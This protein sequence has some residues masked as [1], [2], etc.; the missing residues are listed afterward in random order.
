V[1][2]A[3]EPCRV[4]LATPPPGSRFCP[5]CG[6]GL[7][8]AEADPL[9][10]V[11][12]T[13]TVLFCDLADSTA[14]GERLDPEALRTVMVRYYQRSREC[15]ERYGGT[16]EKFIGDAVVAVF[17]VPVLREDDAPRAVRAAADLLAAV[18]AL[19]DELMATVGVR[20]AVRIGLNTGEVVTHGEPGSAS[21]LASGGP[22]N[23]AARLQQHAGPGQVLLGEKTWQLAAATVRAEPVAP[24]TVK[25]RDQPVPAYRLVAVDTD[26]A[27]SDL[28]LVGREPEL[29]QWEL[30]LDRLDRDRSCQ[31]VTLL[32]DA[33][34]GKS[35]L[36]R[37][38]AAVAAGRGAAVGVGR[39]APHGDGPSLRALAQAL[40]AVLPAPGP[41][42]PVGEV[43]EALAG[44]RA[45]LL[46]DEAPGVPS[47]QLGWALHA[48][49]GW[50]S[51]DRPLVLVLDDL[52][53]ARQPLLDVLDLLA[54]WAEDCAVALV[55]VARPDL[56]EA[57]PGWG[58]GRLNG[59]TM[60][61]PPLAD[62]AARLLAGCFAETV[63]HAGP[64]LDALL[65]RAAGNPFHLE[66]LVAMGAADGPAAL[67]PTVAALIAARLE[68]LDPAERTVL[69]HAAVIGREFSRHSLAALADTDREPAAALRALCR[70]RLVERTRR[71][72]GDTGYRFVNT[73]IQ[74]VTYAGM[75]K[76]LRARLHL[77]LADHLDTAAGLAP[78]VGGHRE[79]AVLLLAELG[80]LDPDTAELRDR[81]AAHLGAEGV[82][83][84]RRSD[85]QH[86]ADLLE[87]SLRLAGAD[88]PGQL[89]YAEQLAEARLLLGDAG[90]AVGMLRA[91]VDAAAAAGDARVGG[92]GRLL[93]A[94]LEP[95]G[96][97]APGGLGEGLAEQVLPVFEAAGDDLG[98]ARA[99]LRLGQARQRR[100]RYGAADD[101]LDRALGHAV[102]AG[103]ELERATALGAMAFS[104]WHGPEP[105]ETA[106]ARCEG[107]LDRYVSGRRAAWA[108]V[109]CPLAVLRA[110]GGD[111]DAADVLLAGAEQVI[112]ELGHAYAAA[113]VPVFAAHVAGLAGRWDRAERLLTGSRA[114][115]ARL[116]DHASHAA[117]GLDLARAL[118][119]LGRPADAA[120]CLPEQPDGPLSVAT[121]AGIRARLLAAAGE[122]AAAA[123]W[124]VLA[125]AESR[126]TDSTPCQGAALLDHAHVLLAA[127]DRA[128]AARLAG[129]ARDR[130]AAKGHRIG[131]GRADQL[132]GQ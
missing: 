103:A 82:R 124:A 46:H 32:G 74:D 29:R 48:V 104:W 1:S 79:R 16:V 105:V 113:S 99:C 39:C 80:P 90:A 5:S 69:R 44:I 125:V 30:V 13:V 12:K 132:I 95:G 36:A 10:Q 72:P 127:G 15:L 65:E 121:A 66:Q 17:G 45:G 81:T 98:S 14:L 11:R 75:A 71:A 33:G 109:A 128:G 123:G 93:L 89:W 78:E 115:Y 87:R 92:H 96:A 34:V 23:L 50:L 38:Y 41:G 51:R 27:Q 20:I 86:A 59:T 25:G 63:A 130:F 8:A 114:E 112:G 43:G 52:H 101:L 94:L 57:R 64:A 22:V 26:A 2:G 68:R 91:V 83:V 129:A 73:L 53:W 9:S 106:I 118:L 111:T 40:R 37:E 107:L 3:A 97:G 77:R 76:R 120:A 119:H 47:D 49:L 24:L 85:L 58:S 126:V 56:L 70:H 18:A 42:D 55:C 84:M 122:H 31:V 21:S 61:L 19:N 116:G 110:T 108:A 35:R 54:D 100:G 6:A 62:D 4:C 67:P 7:G 102:A 131:L 117:A 60:M 28:P 88:R